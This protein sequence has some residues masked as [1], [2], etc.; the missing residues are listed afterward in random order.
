MPS[1]Y[2]PPVARVE[3]PADL[4]LSVSK[5][6]NLI[7]IQFALPAAAIVALGTLVADR[8]SDHSDDPFGLSSPGLLLLSAVLYSI[9]ALAWS[10][11][12]CMLTA[13]VFDA[14]RRTSFLV[15]AAFGVAFALLTP[16]LGFLLSTAPFGLFLSV[17][18]V[19][20]VAFPV[21]S[22]WQI[23]RRASSPNTSLERT[24]EG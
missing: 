20:V 1:P 17:M 8:F 13:R 12:I 6:S 22:T 4:V 14:R 7:G 2:A 15:C 11:F 19:W 9:G 18:G 23:V 10:W 3:D 5:A 16:A 24:R 21:A